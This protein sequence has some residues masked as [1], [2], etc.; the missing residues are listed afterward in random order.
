MGPADALI[1]AH[2]HPRPN[3][4]APR[5]LHTE[6]GAG[7]EAAAA[8]A[9]RPAAARLRHPPPPKMNRPNEKA[10]RVARPAT[11]LLYSRT[12]NLVLFARGR[13]SGRSPVAVGKRD[14][15][16]GALLVIPPS[17]VIVMGM[18]AYSRLAVSISMVAPAIRL[19]PWPACTMPSGSCPGLR[20]GAAV[21]RAGRLHARF[22]GARVVAG[23]LYNT[24]QCRK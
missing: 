6:G 17:I 5:Q 15:L 24:F 20:V 21:T 22:H 16:R 8:A 7:P 9:R 10:P 14:N 18:W 3:E 12:G 13:R 1:R 4:Q 23:T 19:H 2:P 11:L